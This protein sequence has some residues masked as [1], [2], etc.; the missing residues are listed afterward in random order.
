MAKS[1]GMASLVKIPMMLTACCCMW[2][3]E[4]T[5]CEQSTEKKARVQINVPDTHP[6][7]THTYLLLVDSMIRRA[8]EK[9][10]LR[11]IFPTS[12]R[13][14]KANISMALTMFPYIYDFLDT[15]L[16]LCRLAYTDLI[17]DETKLVFQKEEF[18]KK[19]GHSLVQLALK[20]GLI[21]QSKA[22]GRFHQQNVSINFYHKSVQEF[23]A[24]VHLTCTDK[25]DIRS[26]CTSLDKIM[27]V[28]NIITFMI[29]MHLSS[30]CCVSTHIMNIAKEHPGTQQYRRTIFHGDEAR[31][32]QLYQAQCRWY[33]EATYCQA[34][35]VDTSTPPILH[36]SDIYL[37]E[38]SDSDI[39]RI[40]EEVMYDNI[41]NIMSVALAFVDHPVKR[42]LQFLPPC[43]HLSALYISYTRNNEDNDQLLSVIPH[44][45]QLDNIA[46][47]GAASV[48]A[49][50]ADNVDD[51]L[52][53]YDVADMKAVKAILQFTQLECIGL[54]WI[55]FINECVEVTGDMRQLQSI[56][57]DTV[58]MSAKSWGQFIISLSTLHQSVIIELW[59]TNIND[60]VVRRIRTSPYFT[61]TDDDEERDEKGT[62]KWL[63]F[64]TVP[65]Q[66]GEEAEEEEEEKEEEEEEEQEQEKKEEI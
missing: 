9:C 11:S 49:A 32:E 1:S 39:L 51:V 48:T 15:L 6:S 37:D 28:N 58:N 61:V 18:E 26:Y 17:S 27:E 2:Y 62:Y 7:M 30:C 55:D 59:K 10:D 5:R 25:D 57:L 42:I 8:D 31:V 66:M 64:T 22:P 46:Y 3:E 56:Y 20:V 29:G 47:F 52:P 44:L 16:P 45:T 35:T 12:Q 65:Q 14:Q 63:A 33:K 43:P 4:D 54:T 50:D 60:V 19:I 41:D 21:S 38:Q 24:A 53:V 13:S 36:V 40:T 23:M 34:L